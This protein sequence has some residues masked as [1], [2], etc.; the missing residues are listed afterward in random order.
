MCMC[1]FACKGCPQSD[2]YCVEQDVEPYSLTHFQI[3]SHREITVVVV[4]GLQISL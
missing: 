4:S 3:K 1:N 2:L